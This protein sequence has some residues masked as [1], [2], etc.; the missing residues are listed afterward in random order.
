MEERR[1]TIDKIKHF[2]EQ[3]EMK[4]KEKEI[5][6]LQSEL[7]THEQKL[8]KTVNDLSKAFN[9]ELRGDLDMKVSKIKER[10]ASETDR[11]HNEVITF[12]QYLN[13]LDAA[14]P[15][16]FWTSNLKS[17]SD[18][19]T[20]WDATN[21]AEPHAVTAHSRLGELFPDQFPGGASYQTKDILY[22]ASYWTKSS[23]MAAAQRCD[24]CMISTKTVKHVLT[25]N[26]PAW[27]RAV[28]KAAKDL[29]GA[30]KRSFFFTS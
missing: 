13:Q 3:H 21:C 1:Q 10:A 14:N 24:N 20:K 12:R 26:E 22:M 2:K 23:D 15:R 6:N 29:E 5:K 19:L 7:R 25:G 30:R 18:K 27:N 8:Y 16:A 4:S 28:E 11:L 17:F 9:M